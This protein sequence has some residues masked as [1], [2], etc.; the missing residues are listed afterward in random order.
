MEELGDTANLTRRSRLRRASMSIPHDHHHAILSTL[1]IHLDH[2]NHERR[3]TS[4][5]AGF[6]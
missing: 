4:K 6:Q 3:A 5:R 2:D 1:H